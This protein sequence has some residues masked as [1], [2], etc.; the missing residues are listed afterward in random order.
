MTESKCE[1]RE[2][3]EVNARKAVAHEKGLETTLPEPE[4]RKDALADV[5]F[6]SLNLRDHVANC[7]VC[8]QHS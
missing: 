4:A 3:L 1:L 2:S 6:A 7:D 8:R 5:E